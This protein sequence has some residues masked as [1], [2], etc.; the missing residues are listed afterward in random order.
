[1]MRPLARSRRDNSHLKKN[2]PPPPRHQSS[3]DEGGT[4]AGAI[5]ANVSLS[6]LAKLTAGLANE[7]D[8]VN[9]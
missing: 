9:Q 5:P 2:Q 4:E 6:D 1:M 7:L 8:A 3:A